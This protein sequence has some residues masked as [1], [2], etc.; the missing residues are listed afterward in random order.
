[1]AKAAEYKSEI[2]NLDYQHRVGP[3][4]PGEHS[5]RLGFAKHEAKE[6]NDDEVRRKVAEVMGPVASIGGSSFGEKVIAAGTSLKAN[7]E[8]DD[9]VGGCARREGI[10]PCR[11]RIVGTL[12][13]KAASCRW[14][15]TNGSCTHQA[16]DRERPG[17]ECGP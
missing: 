6:R 14:A 7:P 3:R 2:D 15:A 10:D 12:R 5:G 16:L 1:M 17:S 4:R 11:T 13:R 8:R 9:S